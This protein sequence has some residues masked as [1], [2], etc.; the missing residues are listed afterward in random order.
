MKQ[1]VKSK[2]FKLLVFVLCALLAGSVISIASQSSSSPASK[3]VG[4]VFRPVQY[5]AGKISGKLRSFNLGFTSSKTLQGE[6]DRLNEQIA[7][8]EDQLAD[9]DELK[10]RLQSYE[11]ILELKNENKDYTLEYADI[12]GT[13][14][15]DAFSSLIIDKGESSGVKV[16]DPV[17]SGNYLVGIVKKVNRSYSIVETILNP[18]VSVSAMESKTRETSY[19]TSTV[20]QASKGNCVFASLEQTTAV[21]PGGIIVTSGIGGVFPKGL[22]IGVVSHVLESEYDITSYAIV[23]P[24]V[25]FAN[26]EDVF[27]ITSFEGQGVAVVE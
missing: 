14:G 21:S 5:V 6:I 7:Q 15:E 4:T 12:I 20:Q 8:Y 18:D 13:D 3:V 9:Y 1:F 2:A 10:H 22:F 27:V 26:L 23:T 24:S 11:D 17:V 19:I 25:D 16:N